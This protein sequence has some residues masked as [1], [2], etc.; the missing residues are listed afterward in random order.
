VSFNI[1]C[2]LPGLYITIHLPSMAKYHALPSELWYTIFTQLGMKD[3]RSCVATCCFFGAWRALAW[4]QIT[5][6]TQGRALALCVEKLHQLELMLKADVSLRAFIRAVYLRQLRV[7]NSHLPPMNTPRRPIASLH[8]ELDEALARVL[9]LTPRV[10]CFLL[11]AHSGGD[12][13]LTLEALCTLPALKVLALSHVQVAPEAMSNYRL[14]SRELERL[15]IHTAPPGGASFGAY[16]GEQ[17][18]LKSVLLSI[19]SSLTL[20]VATSWVAVEEL[21]M[22]FEWDEP[23]KA[24]ATFRQ[25]SAIVGKGLVTRSYTNQKCLSSS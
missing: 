25:W 23:E 15:V 20:D 5:L 1:H 6:S 24:D 13:G 7:S 18:L 16:L 8:A 12:L 10:E 17:T 21:V 14:K 4:A 2:Q 19:D 9:A 3:R 22:N 11:E